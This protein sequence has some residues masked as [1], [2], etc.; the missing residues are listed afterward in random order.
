[1]RVIP[2]ALRHARPVKLLAL[3]VLGLAGVLTLGARC[4]E[5]TYVYVDAD[6]YTHITGRMVNET[7]IQGGQLMLRGT[8]FDAAGNVIATKDAP[9]CPPD[10][11]PHGEII[12]DIRFDNPGIPPHARYEV[13]PISGLAFS[14]PKPNPD[15]VLFFADAVRFEDIPFPPGILPFDSDDVLFGF[16]LRNRTDNRYPVQGCSAVFDN[17]GQ[18]ID[19]ESVELLRFDQEF[20][21]TPAIIQPQEHAFVS[22]IAEDVPRGPVQVKAWLWFGT[23][24]SPTSQWQY[25]E[26]GLITIQT[27]K[28]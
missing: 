1:M 18:I 16:D 8:L 28:F 17:Q 15:I 11:K 5:R 13:R 21:G 14:D 27:E 2:R 6:G 24:G 25:V 22:M 12:F 4:I 20:N 10:L 19:A 3:A 9:P 7:D 26:T 23:K